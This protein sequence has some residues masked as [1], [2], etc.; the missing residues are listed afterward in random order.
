MQYVVTGDS[1]KP[2][3]LFVHGS[4]GSLSAFTSYLADST[5]LQNAF[6]VSADRPGFG[7]SNFGK[8]EPS[9]RKQAAIIKSIIE[10]HSRA[11]PV[12]LVGHS[13]GGPLITRMAI[14]YPELVDALVI[15]SGSID[16]QLEPNDIWFRAPLSTPFLRWAV[17]TAFR[18]SNDELYQL[19]PQLQEMD[20]EYREI[21]CPI[22]F[23]HGTKDKM[24]PPE[25]VE[26]G[27]RKFTSASVRV[28]MIEDAGHFI[29]WQH[30]AIIIQGILTALHAARERSEGRP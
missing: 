7:Y 16:P 12:V 2:M 17:P 27:R 4:P 22:V 30:E 23:I 1:S 5:L 29:P 21:K 3:I 8:A 18:V 15:V 14:D 28:T 6:L 19:K 25:N 9:L 11:R 24:A 20:R 10:T 13:L 26:Y